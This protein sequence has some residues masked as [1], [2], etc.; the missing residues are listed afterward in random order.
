LTGLV[1]DLTRRGPAARLTLEQIATLAGTPPERI[2]QIRRAVGLPPSRPGE[3]ISSPGDAPGL[4]NFD[5]AAKLFGE[6]AMLSFMRVLGSSIARIAE[7]T[8]SLFLVNIEGP[9][10]EAGGGEVALA[11]ANL[12]VMRSLETIPPVMEWLL[13][14]HLE[15]AIR[16]MRNARFEHSVDLV[17]MAV[18][19][20][21]LV[22]F[23][24]V[25]RKL[26]ARELA[27]V[28]EQFEALAHDLVA[29]RDGRL[30]KLI[31][32]EVMYVTREPAAACDV[33]L[34]LV[35][36]FAGNPSVTPR[37]GLA[38]G[39][40]LMR[41][42]DYYGPIVNLASRIAELAVPREVLVTQALAEEARAIPLRF[43]PAGKR[44]LKGFE[45]PVALFTA[46]RA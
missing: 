32:D 6:T 16:R 45:E 42:G 36:R 46:G 19:F 34:T 7:A 33:A 41:S 28:I 10:V 26:S 21:D 37:G 35:E 38:L 3:K 24:T 39:P 11:Q 25:S 44:M 15:I 8:V 5:H 17:R 23:T 30:V 12:Q 4:A 14:S 27:E 18:G 20:V 43:E 1:G 9:I 29:A 22:G 40:L 13:R 2:E 31:G